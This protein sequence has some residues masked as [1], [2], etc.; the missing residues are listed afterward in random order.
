MKETKEGKLELPEDDPLLIELLLA[1]AYG[2]DHHG[3]I[4]KRCRG[5]LILDGGRKK[6]DC[7]GKKKLWWTAREYWSATMDCIQLQT[8]FD[9]KAQW[10][11]HH[12]LCDVDPP[13]E[14]SSSICLELLVHVDIYV[15]ADK[16]GMTSLKK[17]TESRMA[18]LLWDCWNSPD[19]MEVAKKVLTKIPN[20]NADI[21]IRIGKGFAERISLFQQ[22]N[23]FQKLI[24]QFPNFAC[25]IL[26]SLVP[27]QHLEQGYCT[28]YQCRQNQYVQISNTGKSRT[29]EQCGRKVVVPARTCLPYPCEPTLQTNTGGRLMPH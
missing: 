23:R 28:W 3:Y 29:C 7:P 11:A 15:A 17:A 12:K 1:H 14:V 5:E 18:D 22:D 8:S 4:S 13:E 16:Y 26:T 25:R 2:A 20:G 6:V 9:S 19:V 24:D 21:A 10:F 27:N